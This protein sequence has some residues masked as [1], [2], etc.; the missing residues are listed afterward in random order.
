MMWHVRT[1]DVASRPEAGFP[2]GEGGGIRSPRRPQHIVVFI[3]GGATYEE[4]M[5]V[6]Q[7]NTKSNNTRIILGGSTIHST[8]SFL[9]SVEAAMEGVPRKTLRL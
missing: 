3:I 6:H 9:S 1:G 2:L 8:A 7:F 4:S 5:A